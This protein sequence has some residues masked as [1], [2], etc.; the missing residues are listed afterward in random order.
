MENKRCVACGQVFRPH[1]QVRNQSYCSSAPCQRERRR[2]WQ[3]DKLQQ[4]PDYRE[5]QSRAQR[6]WLDRNPD[7]W[8]NYRDDH[9]EYAERNRRQQRERS[10]AMPVAALAKMD[11][12]NVP[13]PLPAGIYRI[14]HV[15]V[16]LIA[17]MDEWTVEITLLS[18]TCPC[19]N[20]HCKEMT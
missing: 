5:N 20:P 7:Y 10:A 6:A 3:R 11:A 19:L 14:R 4:D 12:S 2:R 16:P 13:V 8:R 15:A 18:I 9:P 17:K 1:P